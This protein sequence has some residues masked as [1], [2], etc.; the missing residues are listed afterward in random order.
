MVLRSVGVDVIEMKIVPENMHSEAITSSD[1]HP[2]L[3]SLSLIPADLR[4][5]LIRVQRRLMKADSRHVY[6]H[7]ATF[8]ITIKPMGTLGDQVEPKNMA[9]IKEVTRSVTAQMKP[10]EVSLEGLST[11]PN[12]IYVK[13]AEGKEGIIRL[14][15]TLA[16]NLKEMVTHGKYE[17]ANMIPHV[18]LAHFVASDVDSLLAEVRSA[19]L[20]K[21]GR[22]NLDK[23]TL[24]RV[25]LRKYFG[26]QRM[27]ARA[28]EKVGAFSLGSP[29][30]SC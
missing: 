5:S 25:S 10:F 21:F 20:L 14:N 7:P 13:V 30:L 15:E 2:L 22:M 27:R 18:T 16:R 28:F 8:H 9:K 19:S 3:V 12:V 1:R 17:G 24:V 23:I 6:T 26:L 11:F 29:R 4:N